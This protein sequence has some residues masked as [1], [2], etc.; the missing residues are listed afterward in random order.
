MDF[1]F[2]HLLFCGEIS[3][4]SRSSFIEPAETPSLYKAEEFARVAV[5]LLGLPDA[6]VAD[7]SSSEPYSYLETRKRW[8]SAD[9]GVELV[10]RTEEIDRGHYTMDVKTFQITGYGLAPAASLFV[11]FQADGASCDVESP[12]A[13]A[14]ETIVSM[15]E[16]LVV[17]RPVVPAAPQN[18]AI[19]LDRLTRSA[20]NA[21][22]LEHWLDAEKMARTV[23]AHRPGDAD[24]QAVLARA[25]AKRS[26]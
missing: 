4:P 19:D 5:R 10:D 20:A 9:A 24:A 25:L 11:R 22:K 21:C 3:M 23:L 2:G 15:F 7:L 13:A 26:E 12:S 14:V 16:A 6:L 17:G 18:T 8:G 1:W